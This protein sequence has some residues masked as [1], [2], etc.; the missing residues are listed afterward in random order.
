MN[1]WAGLIFAFALTA[2]G[3]ALVL[4][5]LVRWLGAI[6]DGRRRIVSERCG[7]V[8][9][10]GTGAARHRFEMTRS[11]P[12]RLRGHRAVIRGL[13][14]RADHTSTAYRSPSSHSLR[15]RHKQHSTK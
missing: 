2:G 7:G 4:V 11:L 15:R 12:D 9:L 1:I 6:L 8:I 3:C 10:I 13:S 14:R 5:A